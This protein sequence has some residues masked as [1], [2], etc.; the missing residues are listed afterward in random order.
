MTELE[1]AAAQDVPSIE[2]ECDTCHAVTWVFV[3]PDDLWTGA[4]GARICQRCADRRR[5]PDAAPLPLWN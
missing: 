5:T 1:R 3:E 2:D 4:R